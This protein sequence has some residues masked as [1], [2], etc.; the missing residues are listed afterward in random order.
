MDELEGPC[1]CVVVLD[2]GCRVVVEGGCLVVVVVEDDCLV[3]VEDGCLVVEDGCLVVVVVVVLVVGD[4][5]D[6]DD[7][8]GCLVIDTVV[9][10]CPGGPGCPLVVED[11]CPGG[12]TGGLVVVDDDDE[13][14]VV[15]CPGC[16]PPLV[17]VLDELL[18]LDWPRESVL[19]RVLD[20]PG[21]PTTGPLVVVVAAAGC[22]V[23]VE[24]TTRVPV[25][26]DTVC[27]GILSPHRIVIDGLL[28][29]TVIHTAPSAD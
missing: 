21:G 22:L 16:W 26:A 3:V 18:E 2:D 29:S 13:L 1:G 12:P 20:D 6:A 28:A 5:D 25:G 7:D 15:V 14:N 17:V 4:E 24:D 8:D 9:D 23:V 11:C 19:D 10:G 27:S